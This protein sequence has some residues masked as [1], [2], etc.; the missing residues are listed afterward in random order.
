MNKFTAKIAIL[1]KTFKSFLAIIVVVF[2]LIMQIILQ[3]SDSKNDVLFHYTHIDPDS[4]KL[5]AAKFLLTNLPYHYSSRNITA[6]DPRLEEWRRET[7]FLLHNLQEKYGYDKIPRNLIDSIRTVRDSLLR[8]SQLPE[9]ILTT[10]IQCDSSL[11][12]DAFLIRH[13]DNAFKAWRTGRFSKN[14]S[15]DDFKEYILP[16]TSLRHYGF[17]TNGSHLNNLFSRPL[18]PD[19]AANLTEV[20]NRYNHTIGVQR[21]LNGPTR[22]TR[23]SGLY[24]LYVHGI[25]ECTDIAVW[26]CNILR[27]IGIPTVVENVVGYRD[28]TGRHYHCSVYDPD[29]NKWQPYNPESSLPGRF[30]FQTPVS[31]NIYRHLFSAQKNTP[32]FLKSS[33][34]PIPSELSNPCIKDVTSHYI[35]VCKI[36]IPLDTINTENHLAYLATFSANGGIKPTTW[37]VIDTKTKSITFENTLPGV[38]Y[39]PVLYTPQGYETLGIPFYLTTTANTPT[40]HTLPINNDTTRITHLLTRKYPRKEKMKH[41]AHKLIG[42][43]ILGSHTPGFEHSDTLYTIKSELP[44]RLTHHQLQHTGKYQY[45]RLQAPPEHPHANISHLEWIADSRKG[46]NNTAKATR[47]HCQAPSDTCKIQRRQTMVKLLDKDRNRMAWA[48]EYDGNMQTA[49]GAYP[50]IT[51]TLDEP[52]EVIAVRLAPLNADNGIK[53]GCRYE[54]F[55]WS[56]SW[57]SCGIKTAT[58]EYIEFENVPRGKLYWL[59]NHTEGKEE[60]PFIM[61]NG[62]QKFIYDEI[63]NETE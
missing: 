58:Y 45:Y 34:E 44:P 62:K 3:K 54:L 32:Y 50:N 21:N 35:K 8:E 38:L 5:S 17:I 13:I 53:S 4:Q 26:N 27:S 24:D 49:P 6:V 47:I 20:I 39:I 10:T 25:H 12:T 19:S 56:D 29:S 55:Y 41:L 48:T 37:G 61:E 14:L 22:H 46:Y 16:Y 31:L 63:I 52:Q 28:L 42:T 36:T 60:M 30:D 2:A 33:N 51:L 9:V 11:I 23:P 43:T 1:M 7:D 59:K 18:S 57:Q 40:T 15:F